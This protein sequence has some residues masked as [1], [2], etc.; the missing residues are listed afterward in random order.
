MVA[1]AA[2]LGLSGIGVADRNT[3]AGVVRAHV[4]ARENAAALDG[5]RV[6]VGTR[7]VFRDKTPELL[8]YPRDRAAYGRLCRL[9]STGNLRAPKGDCWLDFADLLEF[10]EGLEIVALP[11]NR[12]P[13]KSGDPEPPHVARPLGPRFRGVDGVLG[14]LREAFGDRLWVG[15][16]ASYGADMRGGLAKRAALAG[17]LGARLLAVNDAI[18]HVPERRASRRR[19]RLHPRGRDAGGG[20][21]A[22]AGQRRAASQVPRRN[23][24]A[25]RRDAGGGDA[26]PYAFSKG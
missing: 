19:R 24:A 12:H 11:V 26:T 20:R 13:R 7:L 14:D 6:V 21:A 22:D 1:R 18:M 23:D 16:V 4:F 8:A 25:V 10:G 2:E 17:R 3:L 9:L 15:T 5:M